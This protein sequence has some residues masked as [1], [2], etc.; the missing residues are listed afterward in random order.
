M[1]CCTTP[2]PSSMGS[3]DRERTWRTTSRPTTWSISPTKAAGLLEVDTSSRP[4]SGL[5][6]QAR[7]ACDL[8]RVAELAP[9]LTVG[10]RNA[11]C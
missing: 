1:S 6:V 5:S 2:E 11:H 4:L 8:D 7:H 3:H 10:T 9:T